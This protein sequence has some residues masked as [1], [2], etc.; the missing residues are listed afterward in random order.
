MKLLIVDD[1]AAMRSLI[2]SLVADLADDIVECDDGAAAVLAFAAQQSEGVL[3]D[4]VLMDLRMQPMDGLQATRAIRAQCPAARVVIVTS[5]NDAR[6][7]AEA[8]RC[9]A[10]GYVLKEDLLT[11]RHLL[12]ASLA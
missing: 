6:L 8:T 9:G 1:N 10:Y 5:Y 4:W 2:R 3:P 12:Q 7:R 11:L